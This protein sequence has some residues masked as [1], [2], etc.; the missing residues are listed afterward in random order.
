MLPVSQQLATVLLTS[1]VEVAKQHAYVNRCRDHISLPTCSLGSSGHPRYNP[2]PPRYLNAAIRHPSGP[3]QYGTPRVPCNTAPLGSPAIR[4]PSG[5]LQ[6]GTPRVPC[7]TAPLGS[8]AMQAAM[9]GAQACSRSNRS[10]QFLKKKK[11]MNMQPGRSIRHVCHHLHNPPASMCWAGGRSRW[12]RPGV[13]RGNNAAPETR[14]C[15]PRFCTACLWCA[16]CAPLPSH[17]AAAAA[18]GALPAA[19]SKWRCK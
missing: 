9:G 15:M 13:R 5:P 16:P 12:G 2:P 7:N 10:L 8:P 6:Y 18:A 3:L 19:P 1:Q 17:G 4:H 11:R 14:Q